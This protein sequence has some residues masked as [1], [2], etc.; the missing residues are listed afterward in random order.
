MQSALREMAEEIHDSFNTC[1][2]MSTQVQYIDNQVE[3]LK[4]LGKEAKNKLTSMEYEMKE[5]KNEVKNRLTNVEYEM[6]EVK[7][8]L[9][10]IRRLVSVDDDSSVITISG[11]EAKTLKRTRFRVKG[12][13]RPDTIRF[14]SP[15]QILPVA[16]D[17][18]L[19]Y[20][21]QLPTSTHYTVD[22][23]PAAAPTDPPRSVELDNTPTGATS[24]DVH[25]ETPFNADS[26]E[27]TPA[28]A[29]PPYDGDE[30][31]NLPCELTNFGLA[32]MTSNFS[33]IC[34][35]RLL[36]GYISVDGILNLDAPPTPSSHPIASVPDTTSDPKLL[37]LPPSEISPSTNS[38]TTL[39]GTTTN[40]I[41]A[42][43]LQSPTPD[44]AEEV[45]ANVP[46]VSVIHPKPLEN[47]PSSVSSAAG[48]EANDVA[49]PVIRNDLL[50][51][52]TDIR[53]TR[54]RSQSAVP[55]SP[56]AKRKSDNTG[57]GRPA[58]R[59]K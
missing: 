44:N 49:N 34:D 18:P 29:S 33:P 42:V 21:S 2:V 52:P 41:P 57:T 36:P 43:S 30:E 10:E 27:V 8:V 51:A 24:H 19:P 15:S 40:Q 9:R 31:F 35:N 22:S 12:T 56:A 16:V 23:S 59:R 4:N 47:R 11:D 3:Y 28:M 54:S 5:G 50:E 26:C 6:K 13:R 58:K 53:V 37:S 39:T 1:D 14:A 25:V 17:V 48:S 32:D 20:G 46:R 55:P 7:K 45:T 38:A